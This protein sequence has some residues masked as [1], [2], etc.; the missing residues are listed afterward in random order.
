M[1]NSRKGFIVPLLIIILAVLI[2]GGGFY[3]Y[4]EATREGIPPPSSILSPGFHNR[5]LF[6]FP[7]PYD[8]SK[9]DTFRLATTSVR[10]SDPGNIKPRGYTLATTTVGDLDGDGKPEGVIGLYQ[11]YGA[12]IVRPVIFVVA[13]KN[14]TS[15][16]LDSA[17]PLEGTTDD[18]IQSLSIQNGILSVN[19]L[20]V[21]QKDLS[22]PHYQ[23]QPTE[24]RTV[25]YKLVNGKLEVIEPSTNSN[26][27]WNTYNNRGLSFQYPAEWDIPIE[28]FYSNGLGSVSFND[29]SSTQFFTLFIEQDTNPQG[30]ELLN[31]TLDQM[32]ARFR[33]NDKYIYQVNNISADGVQGKELFSNSAVTGRPYHVAAY[34]PFQNNSY[35]TFG[36]DYQ[37]VSQTVFDSVL[38]TLKWDTA[39]AFK[40]DPVTDMA[41]YSN[42]GIRFEYPT[43]FDTNYASL[44]V[45]VSVKKVD[46]TRLD[47]NGCYPAM[48]DSGT[49]N[50]SSKRSIN[51]LSFCSTTSG[52][53]GAGQL[54]TNYSYMTIRNGN[55]Y[56]IDYSVHTSNGCGG[57]Q[58]DAD[59][60]APS[61]QKYREC[62]EAHKNFDTTVIRLI[63]QSIETFMFIQ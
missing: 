17:L 52:G 58:N 60:N 53:V 50:P 40:R 57:Y 7:D 22:L 14:G 25:Q 3:L 34:F 15:T 2:I 27:G 9:S 24:P 42:N 43:K 45:Q 32:I 39:T 20:V 19:L 46:N 51:G 11:G 48:N 56:T 63:Q 55:T 44:S 1:K 5:V 21:S 31:E 10:I 62:L 59:P 12:N 29:A 8:A 33:K 18:S 30:T 23:Q 4:K 6:T 35:V 38:S 16:Q 47:S 41:L 36:A 13:A 49:P 26:T 37:S 28:S 61:N 54:Y